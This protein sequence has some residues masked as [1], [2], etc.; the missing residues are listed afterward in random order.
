MVIEG[1]DGTDA[2]LTGIRRRVGDYRVTEFSSAAQ[3]P[4]P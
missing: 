4:L 1:A 3:E 2:Q